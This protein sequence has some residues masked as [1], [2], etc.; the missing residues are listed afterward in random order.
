MRFA[1][2][3]RVAEEPP[4]LLSSLPRFLTSAFAALAHWLDRR[5]AARLPRLLLGILF[6]RG[7]RTVTSWSRAAG[8]AEEFRPAYATACAAGR[9]TRSMAVTAPCAVEPLLGHGR[10]RVAL[11][12]TP[13]P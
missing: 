6:A 7:R 5:S 8:I 3:P 1:N 2:P 11:D 9:R 13:T 10:L 12:D 4:M